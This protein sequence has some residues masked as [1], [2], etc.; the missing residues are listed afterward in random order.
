MAKNM[1]DLMNSWTP[2]PNRLARPEVQ[3]GMATAQAVLG[4]AG[5]M[6]SGSKSGYSKTNP[7]NVPVFNGNVVTEK[8][9]KVWYGDLDLTLD[10]EK[11]QALAVALGEKVYVLRE[12]AARFENENKP[13]LDRSV[14]IFDGT[15]IAFGEE[16][17]SY[18]KTGEFLVEICRSGKLAGKIVYKKEYRR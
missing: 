11:L 8:L 1:E 17:K 6:M 3:S 2:D 10:G 14:A 12:M 16:L 7:A 4:Y 15:T 13:Q 9:G 18:D 5:R